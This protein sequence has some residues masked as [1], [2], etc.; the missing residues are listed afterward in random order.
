MTIETIERQLGRE[1]PPAYK[2]FLGQFSENAVISF[3]CD[4]E[5]LNR[6]NWTFVGA[7]GCSRRWTSSARP[8]CH[9]GRYCIVIGSTARPGQRATCPRWTSRP[10]G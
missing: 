9:G 5:A 1:L 8:A 10:S 6:G 3:R 7:S 2:H 4:E